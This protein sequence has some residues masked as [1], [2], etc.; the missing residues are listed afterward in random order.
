MSW[1]IRKKKR[2]LHHSRI[3]IYSH[4]GYESTT[5]IQ[6]NIN[7]WSFS[8]SATVPLF[9]MKYLSF[10][11]EEKV[12]ENLSIWVCKYMRMYAYM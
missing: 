9:T 4:S 7:E 6:P 12:E 2:F 8:L 5:I 1:N 3:C 11:Y 10:A